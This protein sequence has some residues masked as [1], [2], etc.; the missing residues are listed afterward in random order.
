MKFYED[1]LDA[2]QGQNLADFIRSAISDYKSSELYNEAVTAYEYFKR[3]N[4]TIAQYQ[5]LLYTMTGD[6]VQDNYSANY[7]LTNAFFPIFVKQ[8]NSYLL[9]E[10]L[11]YLEPPRIAVHQTRQFADAIDL[12]FGNISDVA[13]AEEGKH[14][15]FAKAVNLN[16]AHNY[17]VVAFFVEYC[18]SNHI[19]WIKSIALGEKLQ[20]L[21]HTLGRFLQAFSVWIFSNV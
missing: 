3:R 7:K 21:C 14:V 20:C 16:V 12:S 4:V 5:K 18:V 1:L 8:E 2:G 13:S 19:F 15:M 9:G 6:A 10:A 17:H 11:L